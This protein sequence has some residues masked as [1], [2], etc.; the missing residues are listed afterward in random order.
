MRGQWLMVNV[1]WAKASP[2]FCNRN[3]IS[4]ESNHSLMLKM[5]HWQPCNIS[6]ESWQRY[7][8]AGPLW[9]QRSLLLITVSA[10]TA[11]DTRLSGTINRKHV[12]KAPLVCTGQLNM[13]V[14]KELHSH[15][16]LEMSWNCLYFHKSI[17]VIIK[18][19]CIMPWSM[20]FTG[21]RHT[22]CITLC[23]RKVLTK[24]KILKQNLEMFQI[25]TD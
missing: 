13:Q 8:T 22:A 19:N 14:Y 11:K 16:F 18:G 5:Q 10:G 4:A 7:P 9:A 15:W 20:F 1:F 6:S 3:K 21:R 24:M 2:L 23:E 12:Q 25:H 17:F